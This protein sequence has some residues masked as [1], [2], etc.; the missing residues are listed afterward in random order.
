MGIGGLGDWFKKRLDQAGADI[1]IFDNGRSQGNMNVAPGPSTFSQMD[2]FGRGLVHPF[3]TFGSALLNTPQAIYREVQN[4]P[5]YDIQQHVF[6]TTDPGSIGRQIVGDTAAVGLTALAPG[7]GRLADSAVGRIIPSVAP[8]LVSR[9]ASNALAGAPLGAGFNEAN[10]VASKNPLT[11]HNI[12]R[13]GEVG[14]AFGAGAGAVLPTVIPAAK[15]AVKL[16]KAGV[17][18]ATLP[19]PAPLSD[20]QVAQIG[21]YRQKMGSF[22]P[23]HVY[24][25][26]VQNLKKA[27]IQHT[28]PGAI[29]NLLGQF[30]TYQ[31]QKLSRQGGFVRIP[32]TSD[33]APAEPLPAGPSV[34]L[35]PGVKQSK[36]SKSV[37]AS[38]E[39]GPQLVKSVTQDPANYQTVTNAGQLERSQA[40]LAQGL[41]QAISDITDRLSVPNGKIDDQ[42]VSD[43]IATAKALDAKGDSGSLQQ[44]TDIYNALG[45]HLSHQGQAIQAASLLSHRTP[46][47]LRYA[48]ARTLKKAG[49][50]VTP[51]MDGEIRAM[52]D[53]IKQHPQGSDAR[54]FELSKLTSYVN[55]KIPRNKMQA[56]VG[57]WRAGLLSG[58]E[59]ATKVAFSHAIT[60][61]FEAAAQLPTAAADKVISLVTGKR[62]ASVTL[63]G[64][65]SGAKQGGKDFM[66]KMR[67]GIDAPGSGGFLEDFGS[68]THQTAYEDFV[69]NLHGGLFKPAYEGRYR[70]SLND[71]ALTEA[72]NQG[73]KGAD[74]QTFVKNFVDNP[75]DKAKE[76]AAFDAARATN[77][78]E[79]D[80]GHM[81]QSLQKV[82]M[83]GFPVGKVLA[84]F[85]RIPSAI[86]TVGMV[87]YT[88]FGIAREVVMQVKKGEFDQRLMSQ[89][90]GRSATGTSTAALGALLM[91]NG[92]MTLKAPSD[93]KDRA[94]WDLEGKQP[95]SIYVGGKVSKNPDGTFHYEGGHW[96]TVNALG[97]IGIT[98]GVGGAFGRAMSDN[99]NNVAKALPDALASG[100]RLLLDQPY[101]KGISGATNALNDPTRYAQTFMDST[102]GSVIPTGIQQT[103]RGT[104]PLQRDYPN[105]IKDT[106]KAGIPGLR[107]SLPVRQDLFGNNLPGPGGSVGKDI[108][109]ILNPFFPQSSRLQGDAQTQEL[110]R[111]YNV[112]GSSTSPNIG[113]PSKSI[114]ING[115]TVK[116]TPQ[117]MDQYIAQSG[118]NIH[119][120]I[121]NL[122][123]N[124]DYQGLPDEQKANAINS[125]VI[126]PARDAQK[127]SQLADNPK[128]LSDQAAGI[129]AG[130]TNQL[131]LSP[132]VQ[133]KVAVE[134]FKNSGDKT[135]ALGNT[136][137]YKDGQGNVKSMPKAEYD[138]NQAD[139]TL[140][141]GM[142]RAQ[143]ANDINTWFGL[144]D[145]KYQA[146]EAKKKL[147]DPGT[148]ADKINAITL[149]QENLMQTAEKYQGYGGFTKGGGKGK[150]LPNI[151]VAP[152][153]D[154]A[155]PV[156]A[157]SA[158]Q[159]PKLA[160]RN[161]G[162]PGV[163][164]SRKSVKIS[165]PK[166]I[167]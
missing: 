91:N 34:K 53:N 62:A 26:A 158:Y 157:R 30:R 106:L 68:G 4:K 29:D 11:A 142:D 94:L 141:L 161:K 54:Q 46:E 59:T 115:K 124:P 118:P 132:D 43:A 143:A 139:A 113:A 165:A 20:A 75:T 71:Q 146:L 48:A 88:P 153:S 98:L 147:Y 17:D 85:T 80:L 63:R 2:Q 3:S 52:I 57:I 96:Q 86:G 60:L 154:L 151:S 144:A 73:L 21:Q 45:E 41:P 105:N 69:G 32:G 27:G 129:L 128:S 89:A 23:D 77:Q 55:D 163:K 18:A 66:T 133:N 92:R 67:T 122:L 28:D 39:T 104:D 137:Y 149:A 49:V 81:A 12:V 9:V 108:N 24:Q 152:S 51:Q 31:N 44:A 74:K 111:L 56:G 126:T 109:G 25:G 33:S 140:N 107:E 156:V 35:P 76:T 121:G 38:P 22:M 120:G 155:G 112:L 127:V 79:T 90:I 6:G 159:A 114:T 14:A 162:S 13:T 7:A 117:Q 138:F 87:D 101:F 116:L 166:K 134:K 36:F 119:S 40:H 123:Q 103:A 16:G 65:A 8:R 72:K 100:S 164:V 135:L 83:A 15:G 167:A 37:I 47:G 97:A 150:A 145:Q 78:Q 84:P 136:F 58:P 61:P 82:T 160:L 95:N 5:I 99:A 1:N 50:E 131:N 102:L 148:E 93:Q 64:A 110:Q 10:L 125:Q 19:R 70:I 42:V 130:T